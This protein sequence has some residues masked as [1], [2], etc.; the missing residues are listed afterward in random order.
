MLR[1]YTGMNYYPDGGENGGDPGENKAPASY[2]YLDW[3]QT[4]ALSKEE[5]DKTRLGRFMTNIYYQTSRG[6]GGD[7]VDK[8]GRRD[9]DQ[10]FRTIGRELREGGDIKISEGALDALE[11]VENR[12]AR[13]DW[14]ERVPNS[15]PSAG[16]YAKRW[17]DGCSAGAMVDRLKFFDGGKGFVLKA[18]ASLDGAGSSQLKSIRMLFVYHNGKMLTRYGSEVGKYYQKDN[19]QTPEQAKMMGEV[20]AQF[21]RVEL[22]AGEAGKSDE[23]VLF[24][25]DQEVGTYLAQDVQNGVGD[26]EGKAEALA[27]VKIES[28]NPSAKAHFVNISPERWG[29]GGGRTF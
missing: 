2:S 19:P 9:V 4:R 8:V 27:P 20:R 29:M 16:V 6:I 10:L 26:N 25:G 18:W 11:D 7:A 17:V 21:N 13:F 23:I 12:L 3:E 22:R 28:W 24:N 5:S 14:Y 15:D 1:E